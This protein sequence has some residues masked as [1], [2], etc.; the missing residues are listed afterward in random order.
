MIYF[1]WRF[2][3]RGGIDGYSRKIVYLKC[4]TNNRASIVFD[5]FL[6]AVTNHGLPSRVRSDKGGENVAVAQY[7]LEHPERGN[8]RGSKITGKSVHNQ[9]IERLWRDLCSGCVHMYYNLLYSLER[10]G[11][12]NLENETDLFC[13]HY[14]YVPRIS[15]SLE[16]FVEGW[17][18][19]PISTENNLSLN[20][21]WIKG[22]LQIANSNNRIAQDLWQSGPPDV[23]ISLS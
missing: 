8:G 3:I 5:A 9:R 15:H 7:L 17:N 18:S 2:V 19:H 13:L 1:R 20:Q 12:L 21:L 10:S 22:L 14:V 11:M 4:N 6:S 16:K 23:G